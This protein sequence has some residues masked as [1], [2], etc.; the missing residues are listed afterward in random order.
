MMGLARK[1][2]SFSL[3]DSVAGAGEVTAFAALGVSLAWLMWASIEPL[4]SLPKTPVNG[5]GDSKLDPLATRLA[6]I[7]DLAIG[8][9]GPPLAAAPDAGGFTLYGARAGE[10]GGGT[11]IIS[12][13]GQP[14]ASF[15]VGD[16]VAPGARLARVA[17]DHVEIDSSGHRFVVAFANAAPGAISPPPPLATV[18]PANT[19]AS[20]VNA[21]SLQPVS[22]PGG[23]SGYAIT[24]QADL[25]VL[26]ASGLRPGDILLKVN[27]ADV[28]P[29]GLAEY[30]AD[31]QAGRQLEIVYER[32]G[33]AATTRIG[34]PGR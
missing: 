27:G 34:R 6:R 10:D 3:R 15:S 28:S 17:A 20:L 11:A 13:S 23:R 29:A 25:S 21:L 12:I 9:A 30:A 2:S 26:G 8:N 32:A 24:S 16:E 19:S 7:P 33:Q 22:R 14:Q 1:F 5:G 4:G 18:R 31:L